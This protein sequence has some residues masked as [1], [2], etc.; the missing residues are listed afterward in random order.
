MATR[1]RSTTTQGDVR[2]CT[3][4]TRLADNTETCYCTLQR[5]THVADSSLLQYLVIHLRDSSGQCGT[6]LLTTITRYHHLGKHLLVFAHGYVERLTL[7]LNL[8]RIESDIRDDDNVALLHVAQREFT[9]QVGNSTIGSTLYEYRSTDN[10]FSKV[11]NNHTCT[12][13]GLLRGT[14][15]QAVSTCECWRSAHASQRYCHD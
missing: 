4:L 5:I 11:I 12:G 2:A 3:W 14:H 7:E 1:D 13:R 15:C 10:G 6:L 9:V 8:L